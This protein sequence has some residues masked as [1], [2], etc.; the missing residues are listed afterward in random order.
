MI[1]ELPHVPTTAPISLKFTVVGGGLAGLATAY[2][3]RRAGHNVLVV[4][5]SDG[6][7]RSPGGL[8]SSPNMTKVLAKWGLMREVLQLATELDNTNF[9]SAH[10]GEMLGIMSAKLIQE[11]QKDSDPNSS[12]LLVTQGEVHELMYNVARREGVTFRFNSAV[13][14]ADIQS[15]V[16]TLEDGEEI[17]ADLIVGADGCHSGLRRY[18]ENTEEK[19][20]KSENVG[21]LDFTGTLTNEDVEKDPRLLEHK[22]DL[23]MYF[24]N[25]FYVSVHF[26]SA[27]EKRRFSV[28]IAHPYEDDVPIQYEDWKPL[29]KSSDFN[30]DLEQLAPWLRKLISLATHKWGRIF[31]VKETLQNVNKS[32]LVLVGEAFHAISPGSFLSGAMSF[33]DAHTLGC[34]FSA[35]QSKSQI[36][37]FLTAYDEIR[38]PRSSFVH[39]K[40]AYHRGVATLPPGPY[41]DTRDAHLRMSLQQGMGD[42]EMA[43]IYGE[44]IR[45]FT[46]D[47]G[48]DT[49]AWWNQ[50]GSMV[51]DPESRTRRESIMEVQIASSI[52][53]S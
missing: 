48:V 23:D 1:Y 16:V 39:H 26:H 35:I 47:P 21:I 20:S 2:A 28:V 44:D 51:L 7:A 24:G 37:R 4:E 17:E 5:K 29:E 14:E 36:N 11:I 34:L 18:V 30:F 3:L 53:I 43:E 9:L 32:R 6:T 27:P 10:T 41:R 15:G 12:F 22:S 52:A 25:G 13:V 19:M 8:R 49:G 38:L 46:Y 31:T 42:A 45:M 50:Y 33:E 40:D